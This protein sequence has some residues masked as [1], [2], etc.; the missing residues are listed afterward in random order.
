MREET[1]QGI[2]FKDEKD[3]ERYMKL[4]KLYQKGIRTKKVCDEMAIIMS[5]A[6]WSLEAIIQREG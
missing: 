2:E 6:K 4:E 3:K 5:R 1:L